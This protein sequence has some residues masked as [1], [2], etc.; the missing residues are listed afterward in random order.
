MIRRGAGLFALAV[1]LLA[2]PACGGDERELVGYTRDPAPRVDAVALPD[3][4]HGGAPFELRAPAGGL[5]LVYFGFTNCPDVCPATL[6]RV[7]SVLAE[8]GVDGAR[9]EV[10][11]V[12]VDPARDTVVDPATD[13]P[14]L[15]TFV[16]GFVEDAHALAA[17]D[18]ATLRT[19]AEAFGVA[20]EVHEHA[21][22]EPQVGHSDQLFAVDDQGTLILTWPA[23]VGRDDFAADLD[24]LLGDRGA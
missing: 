9:V 2:P 5:L 1:A 8:L 10:A 3:L 14:A 11:M 21:A 12:T 19:V 17:E 7:G 4:S 15:A 16:Q 23:D 22:G 6:A 24:Q 20:Y 18:E 13:R